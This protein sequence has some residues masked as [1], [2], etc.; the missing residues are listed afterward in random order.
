MPKPDIAAIMK[1]ATKKKVNG[2]K[3]SHGARFIK[4]LESKD[5]TEAEEAL[6]DLVDDCMADY[7]K[8]K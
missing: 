6:R 5:A 3:K 4:A 7:E 8:T 2:E 1:L